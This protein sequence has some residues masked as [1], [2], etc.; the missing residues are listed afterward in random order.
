MTVFH[1][2][3]EGKVLPTESLEEANEAFK[4]ENPPRI[5]HHYK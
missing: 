5:P 1:K 3:V 2:L 4:M